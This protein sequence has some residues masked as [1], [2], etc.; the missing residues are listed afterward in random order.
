M[1]TSMLSR[2]LL[3][4]LLNVTFANNGTEKEFAVEFISK[5]DEHCPKM[6]REMQNT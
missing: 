4:Y 1:T 6:R 5:P 2:Y 3:Q